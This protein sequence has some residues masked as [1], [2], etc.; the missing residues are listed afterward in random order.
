MTEKNEKE[1]LEEASESGN[2]I[3]IT[4]DLILELTKKELADELDSV[5]KKL[6]VKKAVLQSRIELIIREETKGGVVK[7]KKEDI[8]F[9]QKYFEVK[10]NL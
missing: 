7:S 2:S 10:D 6:N 9:T 5:A 1:I 4:K 8:E 3:P